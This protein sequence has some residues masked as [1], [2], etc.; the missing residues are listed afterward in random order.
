MHGEHLSLCLVNDKSA[1]NSDL[2]LLITA[3]YIG[4][5]YMPQRQN[6]LHNLFYRSMFVLGGVVITF[7]IQ[8]EC[9]HRERGGCIWTP[10]PSL[11]CSQPLGHLGHTSSWSFFLIVP[12]DFPHVFTFTQGPHAPI[13]FPWVPTISK[14]KDSFL[15]YFS[16]FTFDTGP[17]T[18][19]IQREALALISPL[20]MLIT[21]LLK[22]QE[23]PLF[24]SFIHH[25]PPSPT[26][27]TWKCKLS[28]DCEFH[29]SSWPFPTS[30]GL[31][32]LRCS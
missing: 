12:D 32:R 24:P 15:V 1:A 14:Q 16:Y 18:F 10:L 8:K 4:S 23:L 27:E 9:Q 2:L 28:K 21:F 20:K 25:L 22:P 13:S 11:P 30:L 7:S 31:E 19:G 29:T 5:H 3:T 26:Q 17:L 6:F